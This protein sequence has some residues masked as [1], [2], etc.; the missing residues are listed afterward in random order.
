MTISLAIS[1]SKADHDSDIK[2]SDTVIHQRWQ[3]WTC[4]L[5][6]ATNSTDTMEKFDPLCFTVCHTVK[7]DKDGS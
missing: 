1:W 6:F 3:L 5:A 4:N 7:W 2:D